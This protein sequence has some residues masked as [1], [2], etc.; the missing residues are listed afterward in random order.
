MGEK[1]MTT[2]DLRHM[3]EYKSDSEEEVDEHIKLY[4]VLGT[5]KCTDEDVEALWNIYE[6]NKTGKVFKTDLTKLL[7]DWIQRVD[8]NENTNE[9]ITHFRQ[10]LVERAIIMMKYLD[11]ARS[12]VI[13]KEKFK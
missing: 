7:N 8:K 6:R 10:T 4:K 5:S 12:H 11:T 3:G 2:E 1:T 13:T 9:A